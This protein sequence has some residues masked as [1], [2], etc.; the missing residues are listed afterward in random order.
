MGNEYVFQFNKTSYIRGRKPD[1][2][3]ILCETMKGDSKV[4]SLNICQTDNF[5]VAVNLYPY[6]SGHLM[7]FP[8]NHYT[9]IREMS[10]DELTELMMLTQFF[11]NVLEREYQAKGFNIGFNL[12][13]NSGA[14]IEHI[15]QH[16]IPR[17][18][19]ELGVID[20]IGGAKVIIEDPRQTR[21]K[22]RKIAFDNKDKL[23]YKIR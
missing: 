8:I 17:F 16:I 23:E 5:V 1:V 14:S 20:L 19:N 12:G 11:V 21:D 7:I 2:E 22:L 18:P 15:H 10:K 3:C 4:P 6:N 13:K 9:D